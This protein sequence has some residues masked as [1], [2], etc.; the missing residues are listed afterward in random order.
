MRAGKALMRGRYHLSIDDIQTVAAPC[1]GTAS[2][3]S[4]RTPMDRP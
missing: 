3:N 2:F 4:T 1:C